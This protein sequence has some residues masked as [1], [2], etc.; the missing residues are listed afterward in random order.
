MNVK[1]KNQISLGLFSLLLGAVAGAVVW[2]FLKVLALVTEVVWDWIPGN[3][4]VPF[5]T[6]IV[7]TVGGL[8]IGLFR[9]KYGDYPEELE[10]VM[11]KV[12]KEKHYDYHNMLVMLIAAFLP[13][14]FGASV[15]PEAGLTGVIVGLCYWA[16]D[17]LKLAREDERKYSEIGAAVSLSILFQAPL[18]GIFAVEEEKDSSTA[19]N[20]TKA[21][22]IWIYGLA[23]AGSMGI[24]M[25]L[26]ELFGA[27]LSGFPKFDSVDITKG[28]YAMIV[29]YIIGGIILAKFYDIT[30]KGSEKILQKVPSVLR[31]TL[32]GL[33]LGLVSTFIPAV[34]FS[35]EEQMGELMITYLDYLPLALLGMAFLKIL[36]TNICIQS[37]L[38]GGHFFPVIFAGVCL[39]YAIAMLVFK[40]SAG[41]VVFGAAVVT[42]ALLGGIMKK[43]LAVTMLL[44]L[45]FPVDQC[46]WIFIAAIVGSK[47]VRNPGTKD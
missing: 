27:G 21:S 1:V 22:K 45:C 38:K 5:Y 4:S 35:G 29:I 36:L 14:V 8:L 17:N 16:G 11:G 46:V 32:G 43:P 28:D 13:L 25:L 47:L 30:H 9:S 2:T 24:Y 15:G 42:A 12:K 20:L 23:L 26:S 6:I 19:P 39:G 7:C 33:I 34:M 10:T 3:V 37:G 44:F 18:F 40:E 31:A 41:H